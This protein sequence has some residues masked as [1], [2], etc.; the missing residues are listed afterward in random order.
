MNLN[1]KKTTK[2]YVVVEANSATGGPEL[3][4]QLVHNLRNLGFDAY[5]YYIPNDHS[6]PIHKEYV[7]YDNPFV[8][9][10][11]DNVNNVIIVPE[12]LNV[13]SL[14]DKF[15]EI[16]KVIWWLSVD[17]F[18]V[19]RS[20]QKF[21]DKI[22]INFFKIINK[23]LGK[24]IFDIPQIVIRLNRK[25]SLNHERLIASINT[26][27]VQSE[28]AKTTLNSIGIAKTRILYLSDYL[29]EEFLNLKF[30]ISNKEDIVLYNPTKGYGFTKQII[31]NSKGC[32]FI[33]IRNMSRSEVKTLMLKAKVY[34][35]FGNHPGKDRMPREAAMNGCCIITGMRG[36]AK[37]AKDVE[38]LNKYKFND[39]I[40]SLNEITH[41]IERC[42]TDYT[43]QIK[44]FE[45]YRIKI[46]E[47]KNQFINDIRNVFNV[48]NNNS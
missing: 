19:S 1:I 46:L 18:Y 34:I 24:P 20:L 37:N 11:E 35:D 21:P 3:L 44:D 16:Q 13:I 25:F 9:D 29:N 42:L 36:S 32:K 15:Y 23:I 17:N 31:N 30:D 4:H 40:D 39:N 10:I 8:R 45:Q 7:T 5:M 28:Y 2:F 33:P 12:I 48:S 38:I 22:Y 41:C 26:H 43:N 27:L 6:N 14:I 47:E